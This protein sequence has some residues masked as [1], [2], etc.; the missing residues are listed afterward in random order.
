MAEYLSQADAVIQDKEEQLT[1]LKNERVKAANQ[2]QK[3][4]DLYMND[5]ISQEG[6]GR[7]NKSLDD[8]LNELDA[9]IPQLE[10]EISLLKNQVL[11]DAELHHSS[12]DLYERWNGFSNSEKISVIKSLTEKII[13]NRNEVEMNLHFIPSVIKNGYMATH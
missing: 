7:S 13:I 5:Q 10:A 12:H 4:L 3:F 1:V 8:R 11:N 2:S 9:S 6:F